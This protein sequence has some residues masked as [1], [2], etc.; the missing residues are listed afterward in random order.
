MKNNKLIVMIIV[1]VMMGAQLWA[2]QSYTL[3][4]QVIGGKIVD[5]ETR[6]SLPGVHVLNENQRKGTV[7]DIDGNFFIRMGE[8][9][10]LTFTFVGYN[11][12]FFVL[13]DSIKN[14]K[15]DKIIIPLSKSLV[16]LETVKV[17]AYKNEQEFKKA[18]LE[19]D[20][21]DENEVAVEVPGYYYG[22]KKSVKPGLGSP[23]SFLADKLGKRGKLERKFNEAKKRD[24]FKSYLNSKYN[25]EIVS[26]ITGLKDQELNDFMEYCTLTDN[27][28]ND[29]NE[30]E[31][32]VA[33]NK[34]Y[35]DFSDKN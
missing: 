18:I 15:G 24:Q 23:V 2:Q 12:H 8:S 34:C 19:L 1:L 32:I 14:N 4:G 35:K 9:D 3:D 17:F 5:M 33:I 25:K 29:A 21:E 30:Y 16:E 6:E 10:T 7:S 22:P 11:P 13:N 31:I 26:R 27:F 28:I 20:L